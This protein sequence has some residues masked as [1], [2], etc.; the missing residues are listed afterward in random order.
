M[1]S[2]GDLSFGMADG[3]GDDERRAF[4]WLA[5]GIDGAAVAVC[6]PAAD[7]QSD[8]GALVFVASVQALED[9]KDL[10]QVFL[11]EADPVVLDGQLALLGVGILFGRAGERAL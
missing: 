7:G 9:G 1:T 5:L 11:I 6:D 2:R 10:V 4:G 8:A 3:Q